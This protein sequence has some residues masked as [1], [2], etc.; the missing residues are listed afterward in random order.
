MKHH[1]HAVLCPSILISS[2]CLILLSPLPVSGSSQQAVTN[3]ITV[4][5]LEDQYDY[6]VPPCSLR[7]AIV[8]ANTDNPFGGCSAG[9]GDDTIILPD[10]GGHYVLTLTSGKTD[11]EYGDLDVSSNIT[12]E[13]VSQEVTVIDAISLNDRILHVAP[14]SSLALRYLT[15]TNGT[16]LDGVNGA[17]GVAGQNGEGG[18]AILSEGSPLTLR[19]VTLSGNQAGSGGH[20]GNGGT[21]Q[22]GGNGGI[23]GNGGAIAFSGGTLLAE[24]SLFSGNKAGSG[25][26]GGDGGNGTGGG[27]G[28]TGGNGSS[29]GSGGA[30]YNQGGILSLTDVTFDNNLA[31]SSGGGGNGGNGSDSLS[32]SEPGGTGGAGGI[33]SPGGDGGAIYSGGTVTISGCEFEN[34]N[35]GAGG[36]GGTGG[37]GGHGTRTDLYG[38]DGG[39]G[40]AGGRSYSGGDGGALSTFRVDIT[41][42]GST[43]KGNS[44]GDGGLGGMGGNGGNGED[45]SDMVDTDGLMGGMGGIGGDGNMSDGAGGGGAIYHYGG[46]LLINRAT[47]SNNITGLGGS[48]GAGGTGGMG[49]NGGDSSGG[50]P[51]QDLAGRGGAGGD[52]GKGGSAGNGGFGAG[53]WTTSDEA[54]TLTNVTFSANITGASGAGG[55]GGQGGQGGDGG[56]GYDGSSGNHGGDGGDGGEGGMGSASGSGAGI[57]EG[58]ED[59]TA[60][61]LRY[62]TITLN[63]VGQIAGTGGAGGGGGAGGQAGE[64]C[65]Y[66]GNPGFDGAAGSASIRGSGGGIR[67]TGIGTVSLAGVIVAGNNADGGPDCYGT[68]LTNNG[69]IIGDSTNCTIAWQSNDLYDDTADPLNLGP[70]GLNGYEPFTHAVLLGSVALNH[71]PAGQSGC[72]TEVITDARGYTRPMGGACEAGAFEAQHMFFLPLLN[73]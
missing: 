12:I 4:G 66:D 72:G 18:G 11:P 68:Y 62:N 54:V 29:G 5:T 17:S 16:A 50:F 71:I 26:D 25:G 20:G 15:L 70:L 34:N 23:G 41:I 38:G 10:L 8:A 55:T 44:S 46:S 39:S 2:I 7:E 24:N 52:G 33:S 65:I 13:G 57:Y 61:S 32:S 3:T 58:N 22:Q 43:F 37:L 73:K 48:G 53:V 40:G 60:L 9:S 28:F 21:N 31:G 14:G 67:K 51:G 49:G 56:D 27:N 47:F 6:T 42:T 1:K 19:S 35:S 45:G 30:I 64:G 69:N 63:E 59:T 36:I